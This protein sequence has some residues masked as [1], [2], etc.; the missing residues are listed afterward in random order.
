[1][2]KQ[3]VNVKNKNGTLMFRIFL[4]LFIGGYLFFFSSKL[5]MPTTGD[6]KRVTKIGQEM[7]W[8]DRK[9]KILRWDY[10]KDQNLMEVELSIVNKKFDGINTYQYTALKPDG[11][12]LAVSVVLEEPDWVILQIKDVPK[13]FSELALRME[14]SNNED[15]GMI[16]MYTNKND[17]RM[18]SRIKAKD[19]NGYLQ[20]RYEEEISGYKDSISDLDQQIREE[21]EEIENIKE[22]IARLDSNREY[23]TEEENTQ[24][25]SLILEAESNRT[26]LEDKIKSQESEIEEYQERIS[27]IKEKIESIG[28]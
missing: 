26:S 22:E 7:E 4:F 25:D 1:M 13:K 2:S 21:K 28:D 6:A 18:V 23:Q 12:S 3:K 11:T 17:V 9:V 24:T 19:R 8:N 10:S 16:R 27:K 5:W 14:I 20:A 15:A